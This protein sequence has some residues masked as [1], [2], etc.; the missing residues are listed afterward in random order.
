[1]VVPRNQRYGGRWGSRGRAGRGRRRRRQHQSS[2][3]GSPPHV[4]VVVIVTVVIFLGGSRGAV[5]RA[6]LATLV[7]AAALEAT[8]SPPTRTPPLPRERRVSRFVPRHRRHHSHHHPRP[9]LVRAASPFP[10]HRPLPR[11]RRRPRPRASARAR[12][13]SRSRR[14]TRRNHR[15]SSSR[16]AFTVRTESARVDPPFWRG[17]VVP[18]S[19]SDS[20]ATQ[21]PPWVWEEK[22]GCEVG[23]LPAIAPPRSGRGRGRGRGRGVH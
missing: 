21:S 23:R 8:P 12:G 9:S 20:A 7:A 2:W 13:T 4:V 18:L 16:R 17:V 3:R 1:M 15:R 5:P 6:H 10:R 22:C 11:A 14:A 19:Q